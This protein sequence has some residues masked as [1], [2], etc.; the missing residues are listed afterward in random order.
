MPSSQPTTV[1]H[2]NVKIAIYP[3]R[4]AWRF[5][6]YDAE[7]CR[8]YTTRTSLAAAKTAAMDHARAVHS[9]SA[10]LDQL[11]PARR[12]ILADLVEADPSLSRVREF[13]ASTSA[14]SPTVARA[15]ALF[16][17]AKRD[18][19]PRS[20]WNVATL[21]RIISRLPQLVPVHALTPEDVAV[22]MT[23]APRTR[24]NA[25]RAARTFL[26]WCQRQ[27][28]IPRGAAL[29]TDLIDPPRVPATTPT[30]YSPAELQAILAVCPPPV[31]PWLALAAW[32]GLRTEEI[33]RRADCLQWE[34][35]DLDRRMIIVRAEAAKTGRRRIVPILPPL[36]AALRHIGPGSGR[37]APPNRE[38]TT[39]QLAILG[40][41][42]GGWR[43]NA[44]RHS[45]LTYRSALVGCGQA[46]LE[47]GNSEAIT[48]RHYLDAADQET[49]RAW[50]DVPQMFRT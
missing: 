45:F 35:I 12:R 33:Y 26:R 7:G 37:I 39:P 49:A 46:A 10:L 8:R 5:A 29:P 18:D 15:A 50:F 30:T 9:H 21:E 47:A 23:G 31:L 34:D 38:P 14:T 22:A 40:A 27:G 1:R 19:S 3:W 20:G 48:R 17:A 4:G 25:Y 11:D 42:V 28:H 2:R 36:E 44:L 13:L 43:R 6:Y 24:L 32:A 41:P 16:L